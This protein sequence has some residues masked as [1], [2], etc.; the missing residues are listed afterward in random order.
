MA[1]EAEF[2]L[3]SY[4]DAPLVRQ[5]HRVLRQPVIMQSGNASTTFF[6][7]GEGGTPVIRAGHQALFVVQAFHVALRVPRQL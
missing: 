5:H 7:S 6:C 1:Q 4:G 2:V 3:S